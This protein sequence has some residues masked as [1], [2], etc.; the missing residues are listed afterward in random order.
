MEP[1]GVPAIL[2]Y[3]NGGK[4]AGM[5]P[6]LDELPDDADLNALTLEN[7]MRRY[8]STYSVSSAPER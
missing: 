4:F 7:V 2:A 8:A 3:R 5:V 6:L 1:A